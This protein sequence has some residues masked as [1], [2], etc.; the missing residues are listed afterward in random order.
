VCWMS[1]ASARIDVWIREHSHG[2]QKVEAVSGQLLRSVTS[3]NPA[4]AHTKLVTVRLLLDA[5]GWSG[6][7]VEFG[8]EQQVAE[9]KAINYCRQVA[10]PD[11]K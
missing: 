6:D 1:G 8:N 3:V 7:R 11:R 2:Q 9:F 10:S 4:Y 5:T